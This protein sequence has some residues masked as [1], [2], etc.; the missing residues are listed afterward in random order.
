MNLTSR[1]SPGSAP[2]AS[3]WLTRGAALTHY[4]E[5]AR[6]AGLDP[7][8]LLAEAGLPADAALHP[9]AMISGEAVRQLLELSAERSGWPDF[10]LRM[11]EGRRLSNLGPL[12]LLIRDQPTLRQAMTEV[13]RYLHTHNQALLLRLEEVG[14]MV[15]VREELIVGRGGSVR[16]ATELTLG[17]TARV[18]QL[19]LGS[20]WRPR[21]VCFAHPAPRDASVH[22]RVFGAPVEFGHDFNGIVCLASELDR[23]NPAA[24]PVMA[25]QARR[26]LEA[27]RA[28][29]R[30]GLSVEARQLMLLLLPGG[31]CTVEAVAAHLGVDRRTVHRQLSKEG[32]SFSSLL[33]A[34]RRELAARMVEE[35]QR[36]LEQVASLLGFASASAFSRW[37]RQ[38]FGESA[39]QRRSSDS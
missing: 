1:D 10:G 35:R 29:D 13:V 18:M 25:Q 37:H 9:E 28:A 21:R 4:L 5:V 3:G 7:V 39:R 19:L 6:A 11:A 30:A 8:A 23:P 31:A 15:I 20:D 34:L 33:E 24:D 17:V 38:A 12:G 32:L 14:P 27:A 16:Q 36:P 26:M 22:R 2:G